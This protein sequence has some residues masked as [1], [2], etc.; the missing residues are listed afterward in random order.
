MIINS[1]A[2]CQCYELSEPWWQSSCCCLSETGISASGKMERS[3][4]SPEVWKQRRQHVGKLDL[5]RGRSYD[6]MENRKIFIV[7]S[8]NHPSAWGS[9]G[10]QCLLPWGQPVL[11]EPLASSGLCLVIMIWNSALF[12]RRCTYLGQLSAFL[13]WIWSPWSLF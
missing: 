11:A 8:R 7:F 6:T 1:F 3:F 9:P 5:S 12:R 13:R 4:F 10:W 2:C